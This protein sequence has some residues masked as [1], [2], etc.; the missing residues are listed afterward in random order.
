MP[1]DTAGLSPA[2]GKRLY[3]PLKLAR[4]AREFAAA[5]DNAAPANTPSAPHL[6]FLM[7]DRLQRKTPSV[8]FQMPGAQRSQLLAGSGCAAPQNAGV[9]ARQRKAAAKTA[10]KARGAKAEDQGALQSWRQGPAGPQPAAAEP[11][12]RPAPP[13]PWFMTAITGT[14]AVVVVPPLPSIRSGRS[15]TRAMEGGTAWMR[16]RTTCFAAEHPSSRAHPAFSESSSGQGANGLGKACH[17]PGD[18]ARGP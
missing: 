14:E 12:R 17:G 3:T 9:Q 2:S 6:P 15:I 1:Q 4:G 16:R 13:A 5:A 8:L 7:G 10:A 11:P 18:W